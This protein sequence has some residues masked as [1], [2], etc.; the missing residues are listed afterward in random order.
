MSLNDLYE[1]LFLGYRS[2]TSASIEQMPKG[3]TDFIWLL[4]M[5]GSWSWTEKSEPIDQLPN[6]KKQIYDMYNELFPNSKK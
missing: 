5:V 2:I 6:F 1:E 4:Y 3:L